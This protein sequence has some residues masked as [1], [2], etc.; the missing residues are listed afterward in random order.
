[1]RVHHPRVD[2]QALLRR[3]WERLDGL[4]LRPATVRQVLLSLPEF[5]GEE[6]PEPEKA[7][8]GSLIEIDPGWA[9]SHARPGAI[10]DPLALISGHNWWLTQSGPG[11]DTL[12]RLWRHAVAVQ[13]SARR[14]AREAGDPEPER[15][16]RA[17]LLHSLGLWSVASLDPEWVAAWLDE[18]NRDRRRERELR[19]FGAEVT[20]LGRTLAERWGCDPLVVD[21]AWL[22]ADRDG[23]LDRLAS[24]PARLAIIQEAYAWAEQ[25]PWS[26]SGGAARELGSAEPRLRVLVAE[27][28]VRC[29]S[30]FVAHDATVHEE[31][32]TRENAR[33]RIQLAS[34]RDGVAERD[35][36]LQTFRES[37][38]SE[39]P[40]AWAERV[41]RAWCDEPEVATARAAW[42]DADGPEATPPERSPE[43]V[44][45]LGTVGPPVAEIH[46]WT[47]GTDRAEPHVPA[48]LDA[49][50]AW[51][52]LVADRARLSDRLEG[53]LR[54]YRESIERAEPKLRQA[55]L[56]AL[57]EFAA[58][59]GHELNNPL[60]V[61]VGRAQ[62]LL[63]NEADAGRL[64][65]LRAIIVQAQRAH[66]ILR[67][68]MFV[69]RVPEPRP[70]SCQP[71]E[72]VKACLRDFK[73]EAEARGVRLALDCAESNARAWADHDALRQLL[74][75]L[76][77]N[78]LE[79][80]AKGGKIQ[81]TTAGDPGS[82]RW[83]VQDNGRGIS[84]L[85][86]QH[87][88]DPFYCGRQAGRGLGL[89]L[90]RAARLVS[91]AGGELRWHSVPGQGSTFHVHLPLAAPPK[92]PV[93]P[94]LPD[95]EPPEPSNGSGPR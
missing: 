19:T 44:I 90:T 49:W 47:D 94:A 22:H 14:L 31:R 28:Q 1:M 10:G 93:V 53:A 62:L 85:E 29:A 80:T 23:G 81:V 72:I 20:S 5:P 4:P 54:A 34:L 42:K 74:E 36:F 9:L 6:P 66:R 56:D 67:D 78:A 50:N 39:R 16:A 87:L 11:A 52:D 8:L 40:E 32:L 57:A 61:I 60:A 12:H 73:A 69:A 24:D 15:V 38:P 86:G 35:R 84:A 83:T 63:A 89:G 33:L 71:D 7:K 45:P 30:A 65:S 91:Q 55:K 68:L 51:A 75:A 43:R 46:L 59:A 64:R 21:A 26:L 13:Q 37:E 58:G 41:G 82:L 79:A 70:R 95:R 76:L 3:R 77:R 27:V 25:T 88:F 2:S 17:G 48:T 92:P 18:E